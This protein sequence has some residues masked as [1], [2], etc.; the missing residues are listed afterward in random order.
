MGYVS[1]EHARGALWL[2]ADELGIERAAAF[3]CAAHPDDK[4]NPMR[5][6]NARMLIEIMKYYEVQPHEF[7]FVGDR[8]AGGG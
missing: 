6:P 5:K 3:M 8:P 1:F 2:L 7:L 4:A